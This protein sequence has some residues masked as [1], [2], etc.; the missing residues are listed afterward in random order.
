[1]DSKKIMQK[2]HGLNNIL[3]AQEQSWKLERKHMHMIQ[4]RINSIE[5]ELAQT[6]SKLGELNRQYV[7]ALEIEREA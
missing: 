2:I 3:D 1:M 4:M 7:K 5:S 6:R